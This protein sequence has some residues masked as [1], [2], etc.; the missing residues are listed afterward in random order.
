MKFPD[1]SR[2]SLTFRRNGPFSSFPRFSMNP[3]L[4]QRPAS[5]LVCCRSEQFPINEYQYWQQLALYNLP[6]FH[7]FLRRTLEFTILVDGIKDMT[8][9]GNNIINKTHT[10]QFIALGVKNL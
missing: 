1:F 2:F 5:N 7:A 8:E 6:L 3:E 4:G 10:L 9:T